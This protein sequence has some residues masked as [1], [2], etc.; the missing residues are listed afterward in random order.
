MR[1]QAGTVT[2]ID[3]DHVDIT[4]PGYHIRIVEIAPGVFLI[5]GLT[6]HSL[7]TLVIR[8]TSRNQVTLRE[9]AGRIQPVARPHRVLDAH[10]LDVW[11]DLTYH[12]LYD[13]WGTYEADRMDLWEF[14]SDHHTDVWKEFEKYVLENLLKGGGV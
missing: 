2:T 11:L 13:H 8:P 14:I 3:P 1:V 6:D 5:T 9:D 4:G 7:S 12:A 10:A